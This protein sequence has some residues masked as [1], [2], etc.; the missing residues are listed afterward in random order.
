MIPEKRF[1]EGRTWAGA[2]Q[3]M[4]MIDKGE[5][6]IVLIA[7]DTIPK[8]VVLGIENAVKANG[9]EHYYS[10][11]EEIAKIIGCPRPTAAACLV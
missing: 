10:T 5:A 3:T 7:E 4:R 11:K 8:E 2:N 6:K 9:I 1:K